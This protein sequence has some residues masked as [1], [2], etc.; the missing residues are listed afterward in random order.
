[1]SHGGGVP[2]AKADCKR[3]GGFSGRLL[4]YTLLRMSN[5]FS[6][7]MARVLLVV[8]AMT[9]LSPAL[10]VQLT[11][12]HEQLHAVAERAAAATQAHEHDADDDDDAHGVVGHLF[13]HMPFS[14]GSAFDFVS[15][16]FLS[17]VSL[18]PLRFPPSSGIPEL[19]FK[20]PRVLPFV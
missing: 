3:S 2:N 13:L 5:R 18:T 10:G 16:Q 8:V 1:M 12:D 14:F 17:G 7:L 15:P 20:P 6:H 11:S 4:S 9:F 19:P